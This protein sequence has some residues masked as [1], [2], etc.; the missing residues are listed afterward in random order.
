M[1]K[2]QN[3]SRR[4]YRLWKGRSPATLPC[5]CTWLSLSPGWEVRFSILQ[6]KTLQCYS[7]LS[8]GACGVLQLELSQGFLYESVFAMLCIPP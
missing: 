2:L 4:W 6:C 5:G 8:M 7:S 3:N 1:Q